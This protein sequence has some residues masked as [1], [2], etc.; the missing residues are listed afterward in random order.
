[1]TFSGG[2]L[3]NSTR[4]EGGTDGTKIGNTGDR[5]RVEAAYSSAIFP[6][7]WDKNL[8]Y[9]DMNVSNG[10]IARGTSIPTS[11]NWTTIYNYSGSGYLGGLLINVDTFLGWEFR[12][13]IDSTTIFTFVSEDLT[14]DTIYDVD[15][16]TDLN[17]AFL[18]I[19]KGAHD[20][21]TWHPPLSQP[22]KYDSNVTVQ[23]RRPTA[24]AKKF[25][26]GLI[27]IGKLT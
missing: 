9:E 16:V 3:D 26:A 2:D 23:I 6:A 27:L 1:M 17:T 24:G 11:A 19:S 15:D 8:R 13:Q 25:Q 12:L 18:G 4:L 20:K 14:S 10:G 5:L 7:S 21:F 22:M